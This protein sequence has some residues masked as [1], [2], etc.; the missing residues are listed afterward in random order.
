MG[1]K[2]ASPEVG[3]GSELSTRPALS[4]VW[5]TLMSPPNVDGRK[6][7]CASAPLPEAMVP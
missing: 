3:I 6:A 4:D 1:G 5:I 7:V 2:E